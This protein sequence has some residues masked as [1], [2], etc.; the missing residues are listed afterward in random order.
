MHA[1]IYVYTSIMHVIYV[2]YLCMNARTLMCEYIS[3]LTRCV[4]VFVCVC[5]CVC[6]CV[7][8]RARGIF[9]R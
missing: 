3:V 9:Q 5:V 7:R 6:A 8:A 2:Y 1:C 4:F